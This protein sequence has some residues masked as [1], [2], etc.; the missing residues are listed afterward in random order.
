M[1]P[2]GQIKRFYA[3]LFV[4]CLCLEQL[5]LNLFAINYVDQL[6]VRQRLEQNE[7]LLKMARDIV[8]MVRVPTDSEESLRPLLQQIASKKFFDNESFVCFIDSNGYIVAHVD[9][10]RIGVYRGDQQIATKAGPRPFAGQPY[11]V[12]GVWDNRAFSRVEIVSTLFDDDIGLTIAAHQNKSLVD[13]KLR[14]VSLYFNIFSIAV[15]G[16]LAAF[17]WLLTR[18]LVSRYIGQ[19][20]RYERDLEAFNYSVSHDLRGPV[21]WING[22]SQALLED[23]G[24]KLDDQG[25]DYIQKLR[26][27]GRSIE[28]LVEDLLRLSQASRRE[29]VLEQVDLSR[30]AKTVAEDLRERDPERQ[31]SFIFA[32]VAKVSGDADLLRIVLENLLGNAWKYT[33]KRHDAKIEF[34]VV[35]DL[36]EQVCFVRDN[37]VGFEMEYAEKIFD[38]FERLHSSK[39]FEGTGIGL[40]TVKRIVDRHG[41]RVWAWGEVN[42][43]A[44]FFFT[45]PGISKRVSSEGD[46][47]RKQGLE[48]FFPG[49]SNISSRIWRLF[50][51]TGR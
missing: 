16:V 6:L 32:P 38:A 1:K 5:F 34:G 14:T 27:A 13:Q 42:K 33:N 24:E 9:P 12:Q 51:R 15:L 39:D 31:V 3:L 11:L 22:F 41:G 20:E 19:I 26:S 8:K 44:T 10:N 37:G 23:Y 40:A 18:I 7:Q 35:S 21:R 25:N 43:G 47:G 29:I 45:L 48:R 50:R 17:G 36:G 4:F 2:L 30:L 49:G 28:R 46:S